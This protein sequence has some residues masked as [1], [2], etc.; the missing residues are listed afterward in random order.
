[1]YSFI[2]KCGQTLC[3]FNSDIHSVGGKSIPSSNLNLIFLPRSSGC[4][5]HLINSQMKFND[6]YF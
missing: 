5:S 6:V 2:L 3:I 1:M 4:E